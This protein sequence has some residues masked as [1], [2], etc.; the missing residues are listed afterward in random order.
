MLRY[1]EIIYFDFFCESSESSLVAPK[2]AG[3]LTTNAISKS[4]FA[5]GNGDC[6]ND[7]CQ[8][9]PG[10][11]GSG[12]WTST[13]GEDCQ[14]NDTALYVLNLIAYAIGC[15]ITLAICYRLYQFKRIVLFRKKKTLDQDEL[16]KRA[17]Q[18]L[19]LNVLVAACRSLLNV[20]SEII[21]RIFSNSCFLY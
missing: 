4:H 18:R 10:F 11:R 9:Y 20:W 8:C 2:T 1:A 13:E 12:I 15:I 14:I 19:L 17:P 7:M 3:R 21:C 6:V 16:R 5:A